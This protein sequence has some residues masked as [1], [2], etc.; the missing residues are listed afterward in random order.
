[1]NF[2][3]SRTFLRDDMSLLVNVQ[4]LK[5]PKILLTLLVNWRQKGWIS[6]VVVPVNV[7]TLFFVVKIKRLPAVG[8][9]QSFG[10]ACFIVVLSE[11][12][13]EY[14]LLLIDGASANFPT[15]RQMLDV[16]EIS[17]V[18]VFF[19]LVTVLVRV[20]FPVHSRHQRFVIMV[21][22]RSSVALVWYVLKLPV[23]KSSNPFKTS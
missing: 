18:V 8:A 3:F 19:N 15:P 13:C 17:F 22:F 16:H 4:K 11:L 9:A 7:I 5:L 14:S 10:W 20:V 12:T 23:S 2:Q 21:L 1:M 6:N